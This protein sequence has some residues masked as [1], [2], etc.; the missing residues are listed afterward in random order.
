M[1]RMTKTGLLAVVLAMAASTTALAQDPE[2]GDIDVNLPPR[3]VEVEPESKP[4]MT[5]TPG[6]LRIY[7]GFNLALGGS[8]KWKDEDGDEHDDNLAPTA[9]LQAGADWVMGE[10]VSIGGEMRFL[11]WKPSFQ[12]DRNFFWDIVLKPRGRYAFGNIPLELYGAL[13]IGL[14]VPGLAND[15]E[16]KIGWNIG[17]VGGANY[18]FTEHMG[19]NAEVGWLF[20]QYTF[21]RKDQP[22]SGSA[23][24]S[25]FECIPT[26]NF[27]YAL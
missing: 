21:G 7:G 4:R 27:I 18:F 17:L 2:E 16:G 10:Y 13:P 5:G 1:L 9:G 12:S 15:I 23:R 22:G 3:K 14:T 19:I 8:H 11:W 25:Q 26:A 20:H 24:M 6:P